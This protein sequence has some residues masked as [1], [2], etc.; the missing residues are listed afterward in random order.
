[1]AQ[2]PLILD[3]DTGEDDAIAIVLAVMAGLPLK[4]VVTCHG[5]TSLENSTRN[6]ANILSLVDAADVTVIKGAGRPLE[7]HKLEGENFT[8]GEDFI[9]KNGIC[10][11]QLPQ[12]KYD[13]VLD[14]GDDGYIPEL[15]KRIRQE[16]PVDYIITGPCTNFARLCEE[17]GDEIKQ[18]IHS[19][20]IM[21]GAV[22][23]RGTRGA[24]VRNVQ[25]ERDPEKEPDSWAEFNF[26]CD[27]KAIEI[28]LRANLQPLL[29]TWDICT[30]FEVGMDT[31]ERLESDAPGGKF[32][33]EL[34]QAFMQSFGIKHK[35]HFELCDPLTVMAYMGYGQINRDAV[36]IITDR[37]HFGKSYSGIGCPPVRYF[38]ASK[39]EVPMI[40]NDMFTKLGIRVREQ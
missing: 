12:S 7:P 22:Y 20:T 8:V 5:N 27:P 31:I 35:T 23:V 33:I 34:M 3:C 15:A 29:V 24:G 19:L 38:Y 36:C 21:G 2:Y 6:S 9:G 28:T 4:Y 30:R 11:V 26:Y 39:A 1:M 18:H 13:N 14:L 32:V 17:F 25:H 16:G 40:V 10:N 37:D